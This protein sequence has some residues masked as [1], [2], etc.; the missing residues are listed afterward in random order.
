MN[1]GSVGIV[2]ND[3][4]PSPGP[5]AD[6][7][8]I[9]ILLVALAALIDRFLMKQ[10]SASHRDAIDCFLICYDS[11][12]WLIVDRDGLSEPTKGSFG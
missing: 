10:Q 5:V 3:D 2:E 1:T 7:M 11:N 6:R 4:R 9:E 12:I 8:L